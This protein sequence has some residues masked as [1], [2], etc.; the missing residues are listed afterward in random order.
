MLSYARTAD[1]FVSSLHDLAPATAGVHRAVFLNP[2]GNVDQVSRLRL[3][4]PGE[5][6]AM[7]TITG[8][9]DAGGMSAEVIVDLPAGAAREWTA[10]ELE[11]GV[12]AN[13]ALGDGDGKWRL[14]ISSDR[15]VVAMSLIESPTH[16]LTNLSTLPHV[17]GREAGS[18]AVPLFPSAL[19]AKGRQGFVR[20]AN[21]S[22][23]PRDV[24][25]E[26]FDRT[27]WEYDPVTLPV[28]AGEVA[29]FNSDDL[30]LGNADKGLT[31]STGAGDGDWWL[32]LSSDGAMKATP[33]C[34]P[35][36][37]LRTGS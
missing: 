34:R 21:R 8:T 24:R 36:S 28:G 11:S 5:E 31:G 4:N 25:V 29:S 18:H 15:P 9:D 12:A 10:A 6:D 1:G 3:V 19:D 13:G 32:E 7:V 37:A 16:H 35:M 22:G 20:V 23:E 2:G 17:P 14:R 30:E 26:A 27:D 33:R